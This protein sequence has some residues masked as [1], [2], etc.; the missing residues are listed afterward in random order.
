M[1]GIIGAMESEVRILIS[2]LE[3]AKEQIIGRNVYYTGLLCGKEVVI[4]RC[5]IGKVAAAVSAQIM[6]DR[7]GA[8]LVI[9]TGIA[10]GLA[11]G[12]GI[13]DIVIASGLIQHDFDLSLFGYA[14]G[15][16]PGFDQQDRNV[17]TVFKADCETVGKLECAAKKLGV[18]CKTGVI[19]SGDIFVCDSAKKNELVSLFGAYATEMEG[20]AIAEAACL[21]GV[22]FAV[23][24]AISDSADE[25]ATESF[26][27][28]EEKAAG[29]SSSMI[30][31]FLAL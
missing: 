14:K 26:D 28:F 13:G 5:G 23:I 21:S 9:N 25:E 29:V 30:L 3:N 4:A 27:T 22:P 19:V 18:N 16:I 17:P 6:I 2:K 10:G 20:A 31:E 7:F 24:R 11:K 15:Y 12:I 1:T 8:D